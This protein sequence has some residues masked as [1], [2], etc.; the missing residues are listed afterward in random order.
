MSNICYIRDYRFKQ[1]NKSKKLKKSNH[2][3]E[4][5]KRSHFLIAN[6]NNNS[7]T[8]ILLSHYLR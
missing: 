6:Q 5:I 8:K 1:S 3:K 2:F 4:D 7:Q